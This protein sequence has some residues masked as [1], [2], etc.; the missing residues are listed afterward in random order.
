MKY[1]LTESQSELVKLVNEVDTMI[2]LIIESMSNEDSSYMH[3][4]YFM[5][6]ENYPLDYIYDKVVKQVYKNSF[7]EPSDNW[8]K[9]FKIEDN[10]KK[11]IW[12]NYQDSI[13]S[14]FKNIC[15]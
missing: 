4:L 12:E 6:K 7:G 8:S 13:I 2:P 1:I 14:H 5:R 9:W 15:S 3:C 10:L 11:Y